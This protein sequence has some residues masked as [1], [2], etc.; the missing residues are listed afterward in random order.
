MAAAIVIHG[1]S[2]GAGAGKATWVGRTSLS[3]ETASEKMQA[4]LSGGRRGRQCW[5]KGGR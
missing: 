5:R 1:R 2:K 4:V 3:E